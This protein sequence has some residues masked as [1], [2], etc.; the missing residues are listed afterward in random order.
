MVYRIALREPI[1]AAAALAGAA[2][3]AVHPVHVESVAWISGRTDLSCGLFFLAAF[4]AYRRSPSTRRW[5]A[6]A[7]SLLFFGLALFSK[8]MAATLPL[9]VFGDRWMVREPRRWR[10][11]V[12]G[13]LAL[14]RGPRSLPRG[15]PSGPRAGHGAAVRTVTLLLGSQRGLRAGPLRHAAAGAGGSGRPLSLPAGGERGGPVLPRLP[16]DALPGRP[17]RVV[18][19]AATAR[20]PSS[21]WAGS[22]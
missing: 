8:E 6:R 13:G 19:A 10:A 2:I 4:L 15:S 5:R 21:G 17:E 22:S 11:A 14:P 1:P 7:L 9:L 18:V 16:G 12:V 3:F 20:G